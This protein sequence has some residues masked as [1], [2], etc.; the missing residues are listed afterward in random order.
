[1][2]MSE[3]STRYFVNCFKHLKVILCHKFYVAYYCF[4]CGLYWQGIIHDLSKFSPTEFFESVQFFQGDCSPIA[5]CIKIKGYSEAWFHH[6]GRNKHHWEHWIDS[7]EEGMIP[8][9]MPFKYALEMVCD[10]LGA[11][12]A[13]MRKDF[14]IDKEYEWWV[15]KRKRVVMHEDTF[16]FVDTMFTLMRERGIVEILSDK[17]LIERLKREY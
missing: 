15:R 4:C 3:L 12:H 1:M 2:G 7:F 9:K 6:R 11:G 10:F 8:K 13:Y 16:N 5:A 17:A 14:T